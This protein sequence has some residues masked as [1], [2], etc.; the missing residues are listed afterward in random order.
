MKMTRS[1]IIVSLS[2]IHTLG[3][4]MQGVRH[5]IEKV[6]ERDM[7]IHGL[8]Y[9]PI[10]GESLLKQIEWPAVWYGYCMWVC[11]LQFLHVGM[12]PAVWYG[13]CMGLC[14]MLCWHETLAYLECVIQMNQT[15]TVTD[16]SLP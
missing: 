12:Q 10:F 4:G 13:Y 9:S 1:I 7:C 14:S 16:C 6:D 2:G 5:Q 3:M 11:N 15:V 8:N